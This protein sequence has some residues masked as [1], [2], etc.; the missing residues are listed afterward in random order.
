MAGAQPTRSSTRSPGRTPRW[1]RRRMLELKGIPYKR[2]DLMPVI[3]RGRAE[4]ASVPVEHRARRSKIDGRKVTGSSEIAR[5]L[6]RRPAPTRRS[7]R[8]SPS[9]ACAVEEAE[10][11]GDEVAAA[12][13]PPDPL[14]RAASATAR[15]WPATPRAP[16]SAFPIGL[17]VKT[18]RAD[19]RRRGPHE[20]GRRRE[21]SAPTSPRCP[22]GSAD[23]RLD[24][25]GRARRR[26]SPTPPTS[27]SAPA[28]ASLMTL[29]GS[30]RRDRRPAGGRAGDARRSPTSR[31]RA[32]DPA[33][34]LARAAARSELS[35]PA[36]ARRPPADPLAR[37]SASSA[38]ASRVPS[39]S[40]QVGVELQ[41]RREHEA[42]ASS[43][44]GAEAS[45]ARSRARGR[46]AAAGRRRAGAGRG[47][48]RRARAP[49]RPRS[50][51]RGRAAPRARARCAIRT[52]ALRKS[53]WSRTS[54]TGSVS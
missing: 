34:G 39:G 40:A 46:R 48:G 52:A 10:G 35:R 37:P 43:P 49:A 6:D 21:R 29:R 5:E 23:R 16:G 4:S 18:G 54:P 3:S 27:R 20:R 14:E 45:A 31:A 32:A 41:Q 25:R 12:G 47:A 38:S 19:R 30:S 17:A 11:W 36:L 42:P 50:P 7:T 8:P 33:A 9:R 22:A 15:R 13:G 28:C 1:P 53:G 2:V 44:R 24:R 26:P 51:C